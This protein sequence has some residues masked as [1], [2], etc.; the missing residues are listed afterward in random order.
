LEL[1]ILAPDGSPQHQR[2]LTAASG[3]AF[4]GLNRLDTRSSALLNGAGHDAR[5]VVAALLAG[6]QAEG[7]RMKPAQ[8]PKSY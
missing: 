6:Q 5:R 2:G 7:P 3:V 8:M 1:P 4:L